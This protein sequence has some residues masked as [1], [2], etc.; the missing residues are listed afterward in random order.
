MID[1]IPSLAFKVPKGFEDVALADVKPF[2]PTEGCQLTHRLQSGFIQADLDTSEALDACLS[3]YA[4]GELW[5]VLQLFLL[6]SAEP[7]AVPEEILAALE[8]DRKALPSRN[9]RRKPE[10]PSNSGHRRKP[11]SR[12]VAPLP[13]DLSGPTDGERLFCDFLSDTVKTQKQLFQR[14]VSTCL[15]SFKDGRTID[16]WAVAFHRGSMQMPT[17]RSSTFARH[18]A[19]DLGPLLYSTIR[20]D[21]IPVKLENPHLEVCPCLLSCCDLH[22]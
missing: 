16:S 9:S 12:R 21:N 13:S 10:E 15:A 4:S 14:N 17:Q 2:L 18:I 8:K 3:V 7:V 11:N 19:D 20:R 22:K 6:N 1:R 5:S